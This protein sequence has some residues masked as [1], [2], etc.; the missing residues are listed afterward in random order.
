MQPLC[1][2]SAHF[3]CFEAALLEHAYT[4]SHPKAALRE[5]SVGEMVHMQRVHPLGGSVLACCL[6][7]AD[8]R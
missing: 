1:L 3:A 6:Q 8:Q 2:G 7:F 5:M 4:V